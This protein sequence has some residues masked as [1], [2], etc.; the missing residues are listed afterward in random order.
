MKHLIY[1]FFCFSVVNPFAQP[2]CTSDVKGMY[3]NDFKLIVGNTD[4][5]DD[6]LEFAQDNGFTI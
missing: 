3:V 5:E 4:A 6:L 1:Y 2:T